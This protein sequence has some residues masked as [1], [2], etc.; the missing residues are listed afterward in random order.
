MSTLSRAIDQN[1]ELDSAL[2]TVFHWIF[3]VTFHTALP[4]VLAAFLLSE[5]ELASLT[6]YQGT[7][8]LNILSITQL[9]LQY[10]I[11]QFHII[12]WVVTCRYIDSYS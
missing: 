7:T 11:Y 6:W 9:I 1:S 4:Y 2:F 5:H 3:K 12:Y 8:S 10:K